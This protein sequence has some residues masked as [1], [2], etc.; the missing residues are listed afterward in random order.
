[1]TAVVVSG[2]LFLNASICASSSD[3]FLFLLVSKDVSFVGVEARVLGNRV[4]DGFDKVAVQ[5]CGSAA[6]AGFAA[7]AFQLAFFNKYPPRHSTKTAG[8]GISA[9]W[10]VYT[11]CMLSVHL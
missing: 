10:I 11:Q 8:G 7:V 9:L 2:T 3:S 6:G 4:G 1:V 5:V